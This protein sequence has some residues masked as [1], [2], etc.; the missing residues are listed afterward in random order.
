MQRDLREAD[1]VELDKGAGALDWRECVKVVEGV[2]RDVDGNGCR[3]VFGDRGDEDGVAVEELVVDGECIRVLGVFKPQRV[4]NGRSIKVSL[5]ESGV[6]VVDESITITRLAVIEWE[7]IWKNIPNI[8]GGSCS[9]SNSGPDVELLA[10]RIFTV[11]LKVDEIL[12]NT[13][14]SRCY[15]RNIANIS[16]EW[17]EGSQHSPSRTKIFSCIS[18]YTASEFHKSS[19]LLR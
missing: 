12:V 10:N 6:K 8:N 4:E 7:T 5:V 17:L 15:K 11:V 3:V 2:A 18:T 9:L 1:V 16:H 13:S 14:A 19:K